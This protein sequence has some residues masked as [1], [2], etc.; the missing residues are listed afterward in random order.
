M[1]VFNSLGRRVRNKSTG[2][3]SGKGTPGARFNAKPAIR[4]RRSARNKARRIALKAGIIHKNDSRDVIHKDGNP[5]NNK[6]SNL[7]A[8][9]PHK[10]RSFKRTRRAK[11]KDPKS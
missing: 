6:V 5:L 11:K 10:N 1:T 3:K 7:A 8:Q 9:S 4:K 2:R